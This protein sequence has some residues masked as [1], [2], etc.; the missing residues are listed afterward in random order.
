MAAA[1]KLPKWEETKVKVKKLVSNKNFDVNANFKIYDASEEDG[2][3]DESKVVFDT[4]TCD[5]A[6]IPEDVLE[7]EISYITTEVWTSEVSGVVPVGT[8]IIEA[9]K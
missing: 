5:P 8:I 6:D 2:H 3:E 9:K 4:R 7:M 1:W